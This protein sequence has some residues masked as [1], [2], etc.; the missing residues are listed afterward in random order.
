LL[1]TALAAIAAALVA[2]NLQTNAL[3]AIYSISCWLLNLVASYLQ[4]IALVE[5]QLAVAIS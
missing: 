4:T 3:V 5:Q 2:S 1:T